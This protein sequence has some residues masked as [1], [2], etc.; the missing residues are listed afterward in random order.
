MTSEQHILADDLGPADIRAELDR[1]AVSDVFLKSPQLVSFLRF[2]VE[3]TL[4]GKQDRIKA[5]TIGVE[6]LRRDTKFDPQLDPIVRVEATRLRRTIERYYATAGAGDPVIIDLP[7]GSYIPT[8]RRRETVIR[9][10]AQA[11]NKFDRLFGIVRAR[12]FLAGTAVLSLIVVGIALGILL[13]QATHLITVASEQRSGNGLP[14]VVLAPFTVA[15]SPGPST[16]SAT[17]LLEK[18]RDAFVRFESVNIVSAPKEVAGT[19]AVSQPLEPRSDYRFQ[20]FINYLQDGATTVQVRLLDTQD[21]ADVWSKTFDRIEPRQDA[22]AVEE[23]IVLAT[24]ATLFQ[25]FGVIHARERV[26]HLATGEGDPRYRCV[27]EA[28]ESLRSFDPDRQLRAQA[29]LERITAEAPS[30]ALGFRYLAVIYLRGYQFGVGSQADG[31]PTLEKALLAARRAVELQ[32]ESSRGYNTLASI[33]L[34]SGEVAQAFAASDRAVA[35]NIYDMA[36]L[37]D[38]GGRMIAAGEIDRG[39]ALLHRTAGTGTVR[40]ATHHFYLFLGNYLK[41]NLADATYEANQLTSNTNPLGLLARALTAA[42]S[43]DHEKAINLLDRLVVLQPTWRSDP[44]GQL[45]K[46]FPT[47]AIVDRLAGD[48]VAAGLPATRDIAVR[49]DTATLPPGNGMPTIFIEPFRL[50]GTPPPRSVAATLLFEKIND[51]FARF[52]T[53]NVVIGMRQQVSTLTGSSHD[54]ALAEPRADYRLST[55][56]EYRDGQTNIL[57]KLIDTAEGKVIWSRVFDNVPATVGGAGEERIVISLTNA[58]LQSYSTIRA[59]DRA[60][61]L[62]SSAGDPR[63]RCILEAADSI[64]SFDPDQRERSRTCLER[65]TTIDPGFAVGFAFL[66]ITYNREYQQEFGERSRDPLALDK[67]LKAARRAI[68]IQPEDSRAYLALFTVQ[69]NRRDL[70]SAFAA[71]D[72]TLVLNK[73]DMLA[74]GEYG[75]R[76]ILTGEVE[77]GMALMQRA[78]EYGAIRPSWHYFYLFLGNYLRGDMKE[79]AKNADHITTDNYAYGLVA[80][81]ITRAAANDSNKA[82]QA[83]DRLHAL[84]PAWREDPRGELARA[85]PDAAIIDRLLR[86]L[87]A[88]SLLGRS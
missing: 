4:H 80:R 26:K 10:P 52:D 9:H 75:G 48:L 35:L 59:R 58:L 86:D 57:F 49:P 78:G 38:Y 42:Q 3:S 23:S 32:P 73:Y 11:P 62:A 84:S 40:P 71:A 76:L 82:R 54:M 13:R 74:V 16:I 12:P 72:K 29:C 50:T 60:K 22:N 8:F 27:I 18:M 45:E 67:A 63:Y 14:I 15:G 5:Y 19:D 61:H 68:E 87:T 51:A 53:V 28:S 44:R 47:P 25:P 43:G 30:F 20:G 79:A 7:R 85:V 1:M 83:I 55:A 2:V 31:G 70:T 17:A 37:G 88:A 69:F 66:A 36:V 64:R 33:Y 65:L 56:L 34:A 41:G 24:S 77:K 81:A 21:G 6:V 39:I 46:L